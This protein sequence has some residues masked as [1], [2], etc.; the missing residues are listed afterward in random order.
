MKYPK[1]RLIRWAAALLILALPTL[2]CAAA[3]PAAGTTPPPMQESFADLYAQNPDVVAWLE[4]EPNIAL[5]VVQRDNS[6]YLDHGFD[7]VESAA[8][9]L[10]LDSRNEIWSADGNLIVYGH[11]MKDG[12]MFG[13]FNNY[14]KLSFLRSNPLVTFNTIYEDAAYVPIALFDASMTKDDPDYFRLLCFNFGEEAPFDAFIEGARDK[15]FYDIPV[16][17][18]EDDRLLSLVT[19][20]YS[21]DNGRFIILCRRLRAD[22]TPEQMAELVKQATEK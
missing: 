10:F 7:G 5:P 4:M 13:S 19:C 21:M 16:D 18:R 22:E 9:A 14:R 8:G 2:G 6:Y 1:A 3:E 11:N 12:S 15:S 17:V 20:S